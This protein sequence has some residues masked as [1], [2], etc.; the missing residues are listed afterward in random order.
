MNLAFMICV[1]ISE[2]GVRTF[3]RPISIMIALKVREILQAKANR[4]STGLRDI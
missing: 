2:N 3:I 4:M 1:A